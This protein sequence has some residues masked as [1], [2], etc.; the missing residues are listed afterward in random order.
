[1]KRSFKKG[2]FDEDDPEERIFKELSKSLADKWKIIELQ[3][4]EQIHLERKR[5]EADRNILNL[6]V[7][8]TLIVIISTIFFI[9]YIER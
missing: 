4:A 8:T 2:G 5:D 9:D 6:Q 3:A 1:M 7:I